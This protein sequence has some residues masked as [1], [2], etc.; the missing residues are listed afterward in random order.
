MNRAQLLGLME[1]LGLKGFVQIFNQEGPSCEVLTHE[2]RLYRLLCAERDQRQS[3]RIARLNTM[4]KFKDLGASIDRVEYGAARGVDKGRLLQL[5]T[6]D[7]LRRAQNILIIGPTGAGKSFLAQAL[8][9]E[10][11]N[12]GHSVRYCRVL[13]LLEEIK[14]ARI[15]GA[16]TKLIT[17]LSR[18]RLLILDDFAVTALDEDSVTDLFEVIEERSLKGSTIV[19]AQLPI[20]EWHGVLGNATL[21][22]AILDR[23]VH[24]AHKIELKGESMRKKQGLGGEHLDTSGTI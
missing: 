20:E 23:L 6:G 13:R 3:R 21:A 16:Y 9:R 24:N 2:E 22:D 15:A 11:V 10:A 5:S 8:G 7:Y 14:V 17:S 4:A 19:T 18:Y 1:E 12:Q